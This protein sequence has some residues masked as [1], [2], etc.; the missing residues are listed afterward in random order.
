MSSQWVDANGGQWRFVTSTASWQKLV[1]GTWQFSVL[2]SGGLQ[3]VI[4]GT[5][6]STVT[7][8]AWPDTDPTLDA[9]RWVDEQG[10]PWRYNTAASAW[11]K[12]LNGV[13]VNSQQPSG[14]LRRVTAASNDVP[15][16]VVVESMG[17]QGQPGA[18]GEP[19]QPGLTY[20]AISEVLPAQYQNGVNATFPLSDTA[21][22]DQAIQVFRNGLLEIPGQGYLVSSTHVTFTSPPL[23]DDVIAV[24]YQKAQ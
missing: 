16:V 18:R 2:P 4:A 14:G 8:P 23:D 7:A 24:V 3:R 6:T 19:G 15:Q 20:L 12:L 5:V 9:P 21:D 1:N 10:D 22:L 17:P 13:W 11:Q